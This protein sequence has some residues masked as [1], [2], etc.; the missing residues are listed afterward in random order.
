MY[1]RNISIVYMKFDFPPF[2]KAISHP[3]RQ[4]I[5]NELKKSDELNVGDLVRRL[6]LS[7]STVSHHLAILKKAGVVKVREEGAQSFHSVC[8]K[9]IGSC[10]DMMKRCFDED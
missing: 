7:Q 3:V 9:K 6:K 4:T 5:L 10:C 2:F 8:C 1:H